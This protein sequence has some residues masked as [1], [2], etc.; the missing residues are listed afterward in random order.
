MAWASVSWAYKDLISS[1]KLAQ[2]VENLRVHDHYSTDQG[3]QLPTHYAI[4]RATAAQA[5]PAAAFTLATLGTTESRGVSI[6]GSRVTV[7][8]AGLYHVS[9][10]IPVAGAAGS[11]FAGVA[12]NG[13][14]IGGRIGLN[15][16]EISGSRLLRLAATDV[17]DLRVYYT[18]ATS[19]PFV[20][21]AE[22][23]YLELCNVGT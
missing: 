16:Y 20:A 14:V 11:S 10:G 18:T 22:T 8:K 1:A 15:S 12:V 5:I 23:A 9:L 13:N 21:N 7:G 2:M 4:L 3:V 6:A 19:M 17:V